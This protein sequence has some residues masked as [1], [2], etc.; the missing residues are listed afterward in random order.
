MIE[1]HELASVSLATSCLSGDLGGQFAM[2]RVAGWR[3]LVV[4]R[5]ISG[6]GFCRQVR[7]GRCD[8]VCRI[9][10]ESTGGSGDGGVLVRS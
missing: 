5:S 2:S 8:V 9:G 7:S 6:C 3:I 1:S 10:G 4:R